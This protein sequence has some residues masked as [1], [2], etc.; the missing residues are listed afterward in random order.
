MPWAEGY[1]ARRLFLLVY[2]CPYELNSYKTILWCKGY[3]YAKDTEEV[4]TE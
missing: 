3:K 1:Y 4:S 2:D